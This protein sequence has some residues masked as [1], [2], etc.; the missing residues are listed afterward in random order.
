MV[1]LPRA[2]SDLV[3]LIALGVGGYAA[4]Q[5]VPGWFE[6]LSRRET[7]ALRRQAAV[8]FIDVLL[9]AYP[10]A[11]LASMLGTVVLIC[12]LARAR[13]HQRRARRAGFAEKSIAGARALALRVDHAEPCRIRG[14]SCPVALEI[15]PERPTY[16]R[17]CRHEGVCVMTTCMFRPNFVLAGQSCLKDGKRPPPD[18]PFTREF[19]SSVSRA[20][21]AS[22]TIPGSRSRQIVA[23]RLERVFPGSTIQ[24]DMWATGGAILETMHKKLA[25]LTYRPDALMVYVGHNEFEGRYAWMRE[26]DHYLDDGPVLAGVNRKWSVNSLLRLSPVYQLLDEIREHQRLDAM[27]PRLVTRKLVDR[28][29][30]TDAEYKAIEDDFRRRLESIAVFCESIGTL[31][32]FVIPACNDAGWGPSRS[33]LAAE[34]PRAERAAFAREVAHARALE[35][36][37]RPEAVRIYRELVKRHPEFAET[38]YRLARL[39]EQTAAWGE[40]RDHYVQARELDGMPMRC[41]EPLRQVYRQVAAGHPSVVLVD[42]PRVLEAKSRHGIIDDQLFHDAQH[43]NLHGY[44]ALAEDLM[45][46]LRARHAFGWPEERPVPP[47]DA[48][49]CARHFA[50]S[51]ARWAEICNR[52][53][54]FFRASAYIRFDPG[55][56]Q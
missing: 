40:A 8:L 39:L 35:A 6:L 1:S 12:L 22:L 53:Q 34:T 4:Y 49:A 10:L 3:S 32:I 24:V 29:L 47:I 55:V 17:A 15:A 23:W 41:P 19:S 46:Q 48:E 42:G 14:R 7:A 52:D 43:P 11:I 36:K 37:D 45:I 9:I 20:A 31:P 13:S 5:L 56:T 30:C 54:G 50:L 28:P 26:V 2:S 51:A 27:P 16:R 18:H 21:V 33:V 44:V 38:H 25:G